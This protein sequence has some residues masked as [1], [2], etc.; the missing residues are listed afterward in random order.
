MAIYVEQVGYYPAINLTEA[1]GILL[2]S[3]QS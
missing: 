3:P 2:G 1:L